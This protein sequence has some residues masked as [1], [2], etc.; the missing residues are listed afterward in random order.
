MAKPL[1][2]RCPD[3]WAEDTA[4]A[5][6]LRNYRRDAARFRISAGAGAVEPQRAL[7]TDELYAER[8]DPGRRRMVLLPG[9]TAETRRDRGTG[10]AGCGRS[11]AGDHAQ[12]SSGAFRPAHSSGC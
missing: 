2:W 9:G 11:G 8:A 6:T 5:Q 3:S 4:G 7:G 12:L 1:S 10:T